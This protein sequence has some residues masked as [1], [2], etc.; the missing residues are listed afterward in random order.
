MKNT[1]LSKKI[2]ELRTR[3]G[4]S[5]GELADISQLNLRTVQR[6]ESGET[7]PRGDSLKRL[8]NALN[9]MPNDLIEWTEKE[10]N[11]L[12]IFLNLSTLAFIAFP[13]MGIIVPLII[14][15]L[16]KDQVKGINETGK[17]ILNF[18][19]T[20]CLLIFLGYTLFLSVI[21]LHL[22]LPI[23][24][25]IGVF[26]ALFIPVFYYG[27]NILIILWNAYRSYRGKV[28][29]YQPAIPFLR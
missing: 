23:H 5:Q 7:E 12:L 26:G 9:V 17:R 14:Y 19:I 8:A 15:M 2:K 20:W 18:Q 28:V 6:I 1:D 11:G 25:N 22:N 29:I 27:F 3:M 16:K 24:F 13:I 4:L 10:D 21:L